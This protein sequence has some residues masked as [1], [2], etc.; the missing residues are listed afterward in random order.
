MI[1]RQTRQKMPE[2]E[3]VSR[4]FIERRRQKTKDEI[5]TMSTPISPGTT[6]IC[7]G[8]KVSCSSTVWH[9][10]TAKIQSPF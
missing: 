6:A 10:S 1:R 3:K 8:H 5:M 2:E 4:H 7:I 9:R